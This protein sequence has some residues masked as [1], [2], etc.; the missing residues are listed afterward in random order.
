M[1]RALERGL[2]CDQKSLRHFDV[3]ERRLRI[4]VGLHHGHKGGLPDLPQLPFFHFYRGLRLL[5]IVV[6]QEAVEQRYRYC[7]SHRGRA[8][9]SAREPL[10]RKSILVVVGGQIDRRPVGRS[11][12]RAEA[13]SSRA[14]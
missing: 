14:A 10:V 8:P 6:R 9:V 3:T 11:A 12:E 5:D 4:R 2:R 1:L 13:T 7:E